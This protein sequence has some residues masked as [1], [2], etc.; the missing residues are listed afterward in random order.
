MVHTTHGTQSGTASGD[1][2][3]QTVHGFSI[4]HCTYCNKLL[5]NHVACV[6]CCSR[7][8]AT[9]EFP[10]HPNNPVA[11]QPA[12]V[13]TVKHSQACQHRT[14]SHLEALAVTAHFNTAQTCQYGT[15]SPVEALHA[16]YAAS[17][18]L[19]VPCHMLRA[20]TWKLENLKVDIIVRPFATICAECPHCACL[21]TSYKLQVLH[22]RSR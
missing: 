2:W 9:T 8:S 11:P 1:V 15:P 4:G 21:F 14:V 12:T 7:Q 20:E 13:P 10:W 16:K 22:I 5:H 3:N 18:H 19:L 6:P 17:L